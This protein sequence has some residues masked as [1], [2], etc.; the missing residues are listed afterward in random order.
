[1]SAE[2]DSSSTVGSP[3][4]L[5]AE[6]QQGESTGAREKGQ[7]YTAELGQLKHYSR[8]E[9]S[10]PQSRPNSQ[11][12]QLDTEAFHWR[13]ALT[14]AMGEP[15]RPRGDSQGRKRVDCLAGIIEGDYMGDS[16]E[17]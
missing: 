8:C 11:C 7:V 2:P 13:G 4:S 10:T 3:P 9:K 1:M 17:P 15:L 5:K 12:T 6:P 16:P 14:T